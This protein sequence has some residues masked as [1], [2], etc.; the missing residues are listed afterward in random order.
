MNQLILKVSDKLELFITYL[1][2][3]FRKTSKTKYQH[4]PTPIKTHT[5]NILRTIILNN[6][7]KEFKSAI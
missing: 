6:A 1:S 5:I 4:Y 7:K 3:L 2:V